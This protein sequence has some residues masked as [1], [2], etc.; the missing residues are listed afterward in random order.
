LHTHVVVP[1]LTVPE[2]GWWSALAGDRVYRWAKTVGWLTPLEEPFA[3][4][5]HRRQ[6]FRDAAVVGIGS[7]IGTGCETLGAVPHSVR[8]QLPPLQI[9]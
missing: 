6:P 8:L 3:F 1:N 9:A 2:D 7:A 4:A 5:S